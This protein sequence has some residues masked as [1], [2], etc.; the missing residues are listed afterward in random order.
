MVIVCS[1][2]WRGEEITQAVLFCL[3]NSAHQ[4]AGQA[5]TA[6]A[7]EQGELQMERQNIWTRSPARLVP[8]LYWTCSL[9][10]YHKYYLFRNLSI[11]IHDINSQQIIDS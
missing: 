1:G 4:S 10:I 11:V 2:S 9:I 6:N 7:R 8:S 3:C 5:K